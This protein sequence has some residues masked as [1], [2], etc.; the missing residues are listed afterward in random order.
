MCINQFWE[1]VNTEGTTAINRVRKFIRPMC[2]LQSGLFLNLDDAKLESD[3]D[4]LNLF[5]VK[6]SCNLTNDF[7]VIQIADNY[8]RIQFMTEGNSLLL[9]LYVW[10]PYESSDPKIFRIIPKTF[11]KQD[12]RLA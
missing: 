6:A 11:A 8:V 12:R 5:M 1:Y 9:D 7:E 10:I 3:E 4:W 2:Q